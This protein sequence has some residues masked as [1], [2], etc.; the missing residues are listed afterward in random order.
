MTLEITGELG[1][2]KTVTVSFD[3]KFSGYATSGNQ[4]FMMWLQVKKPCGDIEVLS[5]N[6]AALIS[7]TA[8]IT[9]DE[10]GKYEFAIGQWNLQLYNLAN[11]TIGKTVSVGN[12]S[13]AET[14][15]T[16]K[17]TFGIFKYQLNNGHAD[18]C[19]KWADETYGQTPGYNG[20]TGH[21]TY[22]ESLTIN[23]EHEWAKELSITK[24]RTHKTTIVRAN[25]LGSFDNQYQ[26]QTLTD[27]AWVD[28][29]D[30]TEDTFSFE[31]SGILSDDEETAK[32][33]TGRTYTLSVRCKVTTATGIIHSE[34]VEV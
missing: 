25:V 1:L 8:N 9:L 23:I 27:G 5:S 24:Y 19:F 20:S 22:P 29:P 2:G 26:W 10:A 30:A 21:K 11:Q 18:E 16:V 31:W 17:R 3:C 7:G 14:N 15:P 28:M 4:P 6:Y 33:N 34:A 13:L 32:E 12:Y